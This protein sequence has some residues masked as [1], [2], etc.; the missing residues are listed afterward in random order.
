MAD[1][2][3]PAPAPIRSD[4]QI[5]PFVAWVPNG[6]SNYVLDL[7]KKQ[8][9]PIFQISVDIIQN[10]NFFRAFTASA[11]LIDKRPF[12]QLTQFVSPLLGEAIMDFVNELGYTEEEFIQAILTFLTD[13]ANLGSPT[14]KAGKTRLTSTSPFH[15]AE[16]DL[17]LGNLKFVPKGEEDKV[18][19]MPIPNELISN[20]IRN[21]PYYNAYLEMVAKHDQKVAAEKEGKKKSTTPAPK[22][23]VTKEKPSKAFTAKPP[24]PKPAKEKS[25]KATPLQKAGKG[26]VAKVRNME[27]SFQLVDEPDEEPAHSEPEP[28]PKQEGSGEEY[29][30]ERAIRM[31]LE[32]FQAQGHAHVRGLA[33]Q[34]PVAE[35]I[36]PLPIVEAKGKAI[37]LDNT[38]RNLGSRFYTLELRDLPHKINEAARENVKEA[39]QIDLQA[40]LRDRFKDLS[41]EDMK[42]MLHQRMDEFL[43]EKDKSSPRDPQSSAWKK[44]DT[45]DAPSSSSKQQS[46]PHAEQPVED[47]P[48]QDSDNISDLEDTDSA[49]LPKTKQ[50]LEWLK[51]ILDDERP[52]TLEPAWV[53]HNSHIPDSVNIL[54][55]NL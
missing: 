55:A 43:A 30:M 18:F 22:P 19:G 11:S 14:K 2:N 6:K 44:F 49:Y 25:T 29:D 28:E 4:D 40:P 31:S 12:D 27:C 53:I 26:K 20:N 21:A 16:E 7:Q 41:E 47:I 52:A 51:P 46:S 38:T 36:R 33:I 35:A 54:R 5:L 23:K 15:L 24:K 32:S 10:T 37:N 34:E 50:R 3:V 39:V 9:N 1:K 45:R 13:K 42:E 48:I 17:R 8:K